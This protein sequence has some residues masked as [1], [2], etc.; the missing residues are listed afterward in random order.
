MRVGLETR[1]F[2]WWP[3]FPSSAPGLQAWSPLLRTSASASPIGSPVLHAEN[4]TPGVF[5]AATST[6]GFSKAFKNE[7]PSGAAGVVGRGAPGELPGWVAAVAVPGL[8]K[9]RSVADYYGN[10]ALAACRW[11]GSWEPGV[12]TC[13]WL[14][15]VSWGVQSPPRSCPACERALSS[16]GAGVGWC[17]GAWA[18]LFPRRADGQS[19]SWRVW[20]LRRWGLGAAVLVTFSPKGGKGCGAPALPVGVEWG[21]T[22]SPSYSVCTSHPALCS[23]H[24]GC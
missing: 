10:W 17:Q 11:R 18:A 22:T 21:I 12:S 20:A 19:C 2:P 9:G 23:A 1:L 7:V 14:G 16:P 6:N 24:C 3:Q 5:P 15:E 13:W 8:S 4:H